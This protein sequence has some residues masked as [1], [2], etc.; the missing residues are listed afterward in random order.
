MEAR[1]AQITSRVDCW[2]EFVIRIAAGPLGLYRIIMKG[3]T[4]LAVW[5]VADSPRLDLCARRRLQWECAA[6]SLIELVLVVA[7]VLILTTVYWRSG[8][9]SRQRALQASC[10]NNLQKI[11][12]A[13]EIFAND[14]AGKFPLTPRARTAEEALDAL[15]P[16]YTADTS[17]FICPGSKDAALPPGESFRQR[18]IS[19]AYYMGRRLADAQEPLLSDRQIDTQ[20]KSAGQQVFSTTGKPPGNNHDKSGGN[21]LFCDGHV[22]RTPAAAAFSLVLTQSVVLLN[23]K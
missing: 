6:F 16:Q 8:S 1:S 13:M 7:L 5:T 14:H 18:R 17:V 2:K 23:P 9:G 22:Q 11:H 19:Y 3:G 4:K 12:V 20:S 15:V 10:Q 21:V